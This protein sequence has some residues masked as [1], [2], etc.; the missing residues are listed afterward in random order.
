MESLSLRANNFFITATSLCKF[1]KC[2]SFHRDSELLIWKDN[3]PFIELSRSH[4][5]EHSN[6]VYGG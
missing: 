3:K 1:G 4:P 5:A 6:V 2:Y